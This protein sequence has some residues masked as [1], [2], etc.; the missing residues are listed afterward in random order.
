MKYEGYI[1]KYIRRASGGENFLVLFFWYWLALKCRCTE[2]LPP[3]PLKAC[4][5]ILPPP[6]NLLALKFMPPPLF[7]PPPTHK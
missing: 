3:P 4:T 1:L 2:I 6:L 7:A 5:E